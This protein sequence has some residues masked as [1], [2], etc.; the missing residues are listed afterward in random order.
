MEHV[1]K[2]MDHLSECASYLH[3]WLCTKDGEYKPCYVSGKSTYN[4]RNIEQVL[5]TLAAAGSTDI[6]KDFKERVFPIY[7]DC[8]GV[9]DELKER[10]F[11]MHR[12]RVKE[13][14]K[15]YKV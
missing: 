15:K 7:G 10:L 13:F 14:E 11:E 3:S 8:T 2:V 6:I 4:V 1:N 5:L 9:S 12:E